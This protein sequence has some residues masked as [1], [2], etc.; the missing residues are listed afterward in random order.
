MPTHYGSSVVWPLESQLFVSVCDDVQRLPLLESRETGP[1]SWKRLDATQ[2]W[3]LD[4]AE[5]SHIFFL[6]GGISSPASFSRKLSCCLIETSAH[7]RGVRQ[8]LDRRKWRRVKLS[9]RRSPYRE[10]RAAR[11]P[12]PRTA[13]KIEGAGGTRKPFSPSSYKHFQVISEN[14]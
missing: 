6:G 8:V 5:P 14:R 4:T 12:M 7:W 1:E 2:N 10:L 11:F 9:G 3:P 13:P